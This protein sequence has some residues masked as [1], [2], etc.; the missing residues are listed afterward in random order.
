MSPGEDVDRRAA[1]LQRY[2]A[3]VDQ[4]LPAAARTG[5]WSLRLNHCFGRVLL[6]DAVGGC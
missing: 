1:L 5:R 2:R 6:D 4:E 3:L